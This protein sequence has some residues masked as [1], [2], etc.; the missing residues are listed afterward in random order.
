MT[1]LPVTVSRAPEVGLRS[2]LGFTWRLGKV[3][4]SAIGVADYYFAPHRWSVA[5]YLQLG[6]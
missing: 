1:R 2:Q 5:P 4:L 3:S 6:I